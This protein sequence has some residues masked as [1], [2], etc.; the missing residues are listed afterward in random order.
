MAPKPVRLIDDWKRCHT[1]YSVHLA[2]LIALLGFLQ[3]TL[4]PIWQAQISPTAY[5]VLNSV[6]AALLF[7]A[8]LIKQ[9]PDAETSA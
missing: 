9:G 5:A 7:V 6:L 4:L 3:V 1:F 8:R 2:A